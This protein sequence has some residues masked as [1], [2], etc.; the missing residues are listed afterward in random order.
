MTPP[1]PPIDIN[2]Q[3]PAEARKD[4]RRILI[5]YAEAIVTALLLALFIRAYV[6]QAFKIPTGSMVATLVPGDHLL[7]NKFIYGV[8]VPFTHKRVLNFKEPRRGDIIVFKYPEDPSRDFI[9]R[10]I[11]VEGDVI[12]GR[13]KGLRI[14]GQLVGEPYVLHSDPNL[15][16][17][18]LDHRDTF[19][20]IQVPKGKY[21]LM[22]DNRDYSYDSRFWGFVDRDDIRGKA[23]VIYWSWDGEKHFPRFERMG[24]GV[25]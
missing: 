25:K 23:M 22:G 24:K 16:P 5:E 10:I 21:F 7:V 1:I 2:K 8:E 6:V 11:G 15:R 9:K 18:N 17:E 19:G 3:Q 13:D 12:E 14:N 20:P 4:R